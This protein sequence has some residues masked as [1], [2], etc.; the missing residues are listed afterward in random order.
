MV[1]TAIITL[2]DG[3]TTPVVTHSELPVIVIETFRDKL[4]NIVPGIGRQEKY[5][6]PCESY[7]SNNK[8]ANKQ[9]TEVTICSTTWAYFYVFSGA[10]KKPHFVM[11]SSASLDYHSKLIKHGISN[12]CWFGRSLD[13][14]IK[15]LSDHSITQ[16]LR[17]GNMEESEFYFFSN[18]TDEFK[19]I[20]NVENIK[21]NVDYFMIIFDE[22]QNSGK[23]VDSLKRGFT[24]HLNLGW[25][26]EGASSSTEKSQ[27]SNGSTINAKPAIMGL[28]NHFVNLGNLPDLIMEMTDGIVFDNENKLMPDQQRDTEF[29]ALLRQKMKASSAR[30]EAYTLVRQQ[31]CVVGD[32]N[33]SS[34]CGT[35]RHIDGPND[36]RIGYRHTCVF[37]F[38]CEWNNVSSNKVMFIG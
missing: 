30:F 22:Q 26:R 20:F 8:Y 34:F 11:S 21:F 28:D 36:T 5:S 6:M 18:R 27:Q 37:S 9:L 15:L 4:G 38:M 17:A 13:L 10:E 32:D 29:A 19:A 23:C 16:G 24:T 25:S 2:F 1:D 14:P 35:A 3:V 33:R 12:R 31:V 7:M